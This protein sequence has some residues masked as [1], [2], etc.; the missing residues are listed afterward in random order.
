M[1]EITSSPTKV[2]GTRLIDRW[3]PVAAV[4]AACGTPAGS[5][6]VEKA[7]F[8]WFA[9]RPIAQAR[10]AA[11][12][13]LLP[14]DPK[15]KPIIETAIRLDDQASISAIATAAIA[16]YGGSSPVV[17]D[18]FSGRGIIPLEAAR[19]GASAIGTDLS[20]VATLAGRLL[21]DFPAQDWDSEP[22]L[23]LMAND[24]NS[25]QTSIAQ[26]A[27]PRFV[28]DVEAFLSEVGRRVSARVENF[29]PI[30]RTL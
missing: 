6:R 24:A 4:D 16:T 13:A 11:M 10:A 1:T 20:P 7:I 30:R 22:A 29:Y 18:M 5:G 28:R 14:N 17:L 27:R 2:T 9:S 23:Q 8:S 26:D 3:F 21:A 19:A 25:R 12:T 15:Y